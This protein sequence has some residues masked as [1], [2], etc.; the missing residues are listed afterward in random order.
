MNAAEKRLPSI[1]VL[2]LADTGY[3]ANGYPGA[4]KANVFIKAIDLYGAGSREGW[5]NGTS[6]VS[7]E[8]KCGRLPKCLHSEPSSH[9]DHVHFHMFNGKFTLEQSSEAFVQ[10]KRVAKEGAA[11]FLSADEAFLHLHEEEKVAGLPGLWH[12]DRMLCE[13]FSVVYK[14]Y[15]KNDCAILSENT[16]DATKIVKGFG[17]FDLSCRLESARGFFGRFSDYAA[18]ISEYFAIAVKG[19]D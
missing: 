14:A 4:Q 17:F 2:S 8:G 9:Y 16:P 11:I 7:L 10:I 18:D 1:R 5:R 13:K 12:V 19:K 6:I 3:A 15:P